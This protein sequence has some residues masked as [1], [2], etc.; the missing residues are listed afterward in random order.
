MESLSYYYHEHELSNINKERY[1]IVNYFELPEEPVKGKPYQWRGRQMYEYEIT[2]I[3]G[4][5]LDKD[6]NKH[7]VTLL[8]PEG[9]VTIKMYAGAFSHY[10]KQISQPN[11]DK[12]EILE[13][14]WFKRGNKLL[15]A[16]FRRGNQFI[17]KK[18]QTSIYQHTIA[19]ITDIDGEGNLSLQTERIYS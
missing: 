7:T 6:K 18:Y 12:K 19:L 11:G 1:G 10:D 2:R 16:G 4:T 13:R 9:V 3:A 15:I 14:S 8:T 17:P 5:V